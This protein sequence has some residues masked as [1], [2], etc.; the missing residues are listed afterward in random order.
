M[1][2]IQKTFEH[3]ERTMEELSAAFQVLRQ[4][5]TDD[6]AGEGYSVEFQVGRKYTRMMKTFCGSR[7]CAGFIVTAKNHP[8]YGFG[9]LLKSAGL[10]APTLNFPR[11]NV[12]ELEG[13]TVSWHGIL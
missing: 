9:T 6:Y 1:T 2:A 12:F 10:K 8:Q 13:K 3:Q 5:M 4:K 11:G 7:S